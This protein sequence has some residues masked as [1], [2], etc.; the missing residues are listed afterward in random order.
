[1]CRFTPGSLLQNLGIM[2]YGRALP[3]AQAQAKQTQRG[4]QLPE[5]IRRR[6]VVYPVERRVPC[7]VQGTRGGHVGRQHALLDQAVGIVA[8][9]G[10][11]TLHVV[12]GTEV[13]PDFPGVKLQQAS[14]PAALMQQRIQAM[15]ISASAPAS[16]RVAGAAP[17]PGC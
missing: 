9:N 11:D 8:Y 3:P 4:T 16:A 13:Q 6:V 15:Q 14:L 2:I 1:M 5:T 10:D 7:P 17:W 12:V